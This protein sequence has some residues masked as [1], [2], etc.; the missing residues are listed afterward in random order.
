LSVRRQVYEWRNVLPV[1]QTVSLNKPPILKP[2]NVHTVALPANQPVDIFIG[3]IGNNIDI[4]AKLTATQF[5][6]ID[7]I[8]VWPESL[9]AQIYVET[10]RYFQ[11]PDGTPTEGITGRIVP[12]PNGH[13][14][15]INWDYITGLNPPL[16]ILPH[17]TWGIEVTPLEAIPEYTGNDVT[18]ENI[19]FCF[20]K[21]LLIDGADALVAKKLID[22][23]WELTPENIQRYK[24]DIV[25]FHLRAGLSEMDE[26]EGLERR[27]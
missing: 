2:N 17:Q 5:V 18:D 26:L 20:V 10:S 23:G 6:V 16:Y 22:I 8:A 12:F 1:G 19:S 14:G 24:E 27:V 25:R 4:P 7:A 9:A 13:N 15:I 11:D 21:Y 3:G